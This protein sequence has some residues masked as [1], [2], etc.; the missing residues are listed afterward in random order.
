MR[1]EILKVRS[2]V[3]LYNKAGAELSFFLFSPSWDNEVMVGLAVPGGKVNVPVDVASA[4]YLRVARKA[5]N[6]ESL[7]LED[8]NYTDHIMIIPTSYESSVWVRSTMS[9]N[10]VSGTRLHFLLN[11]SCTKGIVDISIEPV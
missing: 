9:P 10:D 11:I 3:T 2:H 4:V 1:M 6:H 5:S 7:A 8:Y